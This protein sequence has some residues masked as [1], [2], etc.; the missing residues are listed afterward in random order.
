MFGQHTVLDLQTLLTAADRELTGLGRGYTALH[1]AHS[2]P[3]AWKRSWEES[4]MH[5]RTAYAD[6][7]RP[8]QAK[9]LAA[10]DM[11]GVRL[12]VVVAE[13]EFAAVQRSLAN[14]RPLRDKLA[15]AG[16]GTFSFG[17]DPATYP[18]M[19]TVSTHD[20]GA[21]GAL[22][23][24]QT[25]A[26]TGRVVGAVQ[27]GERVTIQ[28]P[29][30]NGFY[31]IMGSATGYA[32][33]AYITPDPQAQSPDVP[34]VPGVLDTPTPATPAPAGSAGRVTTTDTGAAGQLHV[35]TAATS[36]GGI[37]GDFAHGQVITITG[38][39][40]AGFYPVM[41][42]SVTGATIAGF[43][44]AQFITPIVG[45][46][47]AAN[48]APPPPAVAPVGP[49]PLPVYVP[50][51]VTPAPQPAQAPAAPLLN[52]PAPV[53]APVDEPADHTNLWL[54]LALL[55]AGGLTYGLYRKK[56]GAKASPKK[57]PAPA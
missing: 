54:G 25:P 48:P 57:E 21:A 11:P 20:T 12:D 37:A 1:N 23:V 28:A 6:A 36:Q 49:S 29:S 26:A 14:Y 5:L 4:Y 53:V 39:V 22:N 43:A 56:G 3:D 46:A 30:V 2:M 47:P 7:R 33:A 45:T 51:N 40:V 38:P 34:F 18:V 52:R 27:H 16:V 32:S 31:P 41:G 17:G 44:S 55:G 8:A 13:P 50:P 24:H 19:A 9:I 10:K 15:T 42:T 35:R